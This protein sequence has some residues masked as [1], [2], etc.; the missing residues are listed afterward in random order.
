[1][2]SRRLKWLNRICHPRFEDALQPIRN[3]YRGQG[4]CDPFRSAP[5]EPRDVAPGTR[6]TVS[7][8]AGESLVIEQVSL[9]R[10]EKRAQT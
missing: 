5:G 2:K 1:M 10:W 4:F 8:A 7:P 6:E 3:A 9:R